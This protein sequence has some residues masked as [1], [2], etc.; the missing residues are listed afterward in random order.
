MTNEEKEKYLHHLRDKH[1]APLPLDN[2]WHQLFPNGKPPEIAAMEKT[3]DTL[4]KREGT[5]HTELK[6]LK[7]AK[8]YLMKEI[9]TNMDVES[10]VKKLKV[11]EDSQRQIIEINARTAEYEDELLELPKQLQAAN[12]ELMLLTMDYCYQ[13]LHT[14]QKE[15]DTIGEWIK[16]IR[17]ELK[18]NILR[19]QDREIRNKQMYMYMHDV[20]GPS[21]CNIFDYEDANHLQE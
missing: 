18:K 3:V 14:Y 21:V 13:K 15:I 12:K 9:V 4:V 20:F 2:K 1:L 5:L 11:M 19:K 16:K 10:D 17:I 8:E 6:E 7:R